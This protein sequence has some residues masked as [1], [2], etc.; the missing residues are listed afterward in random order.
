MKKSFF[1]MICVATLLSVP[2][3]AFADEPTNGTEVDVNSG[4]WDDD[5]DQNVSIEFEDSGVAAVSSGPDLRTVVENGSVV[6]Y[7]V[8]AMTMPVYDLSGRVVRRVSLQEGRNEIEDLP[9][10]IFIIGNTKVTHL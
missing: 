5:E 7:S 8:N 2:F 9:G 4:D 3:S 6:V 1:I 10:G